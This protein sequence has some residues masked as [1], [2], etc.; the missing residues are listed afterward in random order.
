M[1]DDHDCSVNLAF[2]ICKEYVANEAPRNYLGG[3]GVCHASV[4]SSL[5]E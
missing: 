4:V 1:C 3:I 2:I 5:T